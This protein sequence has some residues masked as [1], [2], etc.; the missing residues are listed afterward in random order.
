[1]L[2]VECVHKT[3][4]CAAEYTRAYMHGQRPPFI[5]GHFLP[6]RRSLAELIA[7]WGQQG[8]VL[9]PHSPCSELRL[10][11]HMQTRRALYMAKLRPS[12]QSG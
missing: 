2:S 5:I 7:F 3:H 11:D 6:L 8:P 9:L 10:Q 4:M 1:M 12:C